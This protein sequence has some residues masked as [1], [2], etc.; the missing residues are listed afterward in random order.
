LLALPSQENL[1]SLRE[2]SSTSTNVNKGNVGEKNVRTCLLE[3]F[4]EINVEERKTDYT[5]ITGD[6]VDLIVRINGGEP[7][8][9]S[10]KTVRKKSN[11]NSFYFPMTH[12]VKDKQN[13]PFAENLMRRP[14]CIGQ[15]RCRGRFG[16]EVRRSGSFAARSPSLCI[17]RASFATRRKLHI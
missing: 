12:T 3:V 8:S 10:S 14:V 15:R 2:A 13:T 1:P 4:G 5:L 17:Q 9:F 11:S 7:C 6:R 16:K